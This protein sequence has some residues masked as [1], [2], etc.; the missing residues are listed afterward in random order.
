MNRYIVGDIHAEYDKFITCLNAVRFDYENDQLIQ[1]GD[2]CDRG[3]DTF[4]VVEELLKIKNLIAI[5]GNHDETFRESLTTGKNILYTQG[6]KETLSSYTRGTNC[7]GDPT[8][9]PQKHKDFFENQLWYYKDEENNLFIHAGFNRHKKLEDQDNT[10]FIWDRDLFMAALTWQAMEDK[11][12]KF[13]YKEKLNNIYIGHTPTQYF[14][15]TTPIQAANILNIDT[16]CGKG[17]ILTIMN[18]DTKEYY[19]N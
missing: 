7:N 6:G 3:A 12:Y 8:K 10:V 9:I 15:Q 4:K 11:T 1:L 17:G 18:L 5:K 16:G 19:Q 2:V 13:K 14:G